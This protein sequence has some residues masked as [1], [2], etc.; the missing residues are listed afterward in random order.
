MQ[1]FPDFTASAFEYH[2]VEA[3]TLTGETLSYRIEYEVLYVGL[4]TQW[5]DP[6]T[7]QRP[8]LREVHL[9]LPASLDALDGLVITRARVRS[10]TLFTRDPFVPWRDLHGGAHMRLRLAAREKMTSLLYVAEHEP[11]LPL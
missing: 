3:T 11:R 5:H 4:I 2:D 7:R 6:E 10:T 1:I 9:A 8:A